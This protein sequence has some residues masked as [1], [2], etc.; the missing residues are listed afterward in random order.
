MTRVLPILFFL[1]GAT[2]LIGEVVWM[3]MLGLVLG[4]T[5]WAASAAVSVWMAGMAVGAAIGSRLA[6][7]VRRH[8]LWYGLAEGVIGVFF[9]LSPWLA[10]RLVMLGASL[11]EDLSGALLV[12]IGQRFALAVAALLLPTLLMGLTLPLLVERLRGSGLAQRTGLLYGVNT[13]G[14]ATGVLATAYFLLPNLGESGS[15]ALAGLMCLL[16]AVVAVFAESRVPAAAGGVGR[17]AVPGT[18]VSG[19]LLLAAAMGFASL[20]AEL[21][22]IRLLVLLLGSRVYAFAILL[23]VYLVGIAGGALLVRALG[24]RIDDPVRAL[25]VVQGL[26]SVMLGV[27]IVV[28]GWAT[29]VYA[30]LTTVV[31]LR[32]TFLNIQVLELVGTAVL[33][34]PVTLLFGASFPLAVAAD[35][36]RRSDGGHAG[37]VSAANTI[38]A[39]GGAVAAPFLLI[40]WLGSQITLLLLVG[41]HAAV[42]LRLRRDRLGV[43]LAVTGLVGAVICGAVLR[44]DWLVQRFAVKQGWEEEVLVV[45]EDLGATVMVRRIV[46]PA[47]EWTSLE[48]NGINVAGSSPALLAIQQLQGQLPMLQHPDPRRV[49]HIGFGS[50]GTCWAVSR[51]PVES[52]HVIEISPRV[53]S[54][55]HR[56]FEPINRHVLDD[57]RVRT[58]V[59][60]G[61]NY[62]LAT[63]NTYDVILS[64]SIHPVFSGNGALY[65]VDYFRLCR[66]RLGPDGVVSMWLPLY[67][68]DRESYLRILAAFHEVFPNTAVWYDR[69]TVNEFTV[70]TGT[71]SQGPVAIRWDQLDNPELAESLGIAGIA[72]PTDLAANLLLGP[73]EVA[74]LVRGFPAHEDDLP[75]VEYTAGRTVNRLVTWL[76][77]LSMVASVR[78]EQNPFA[79]DAPVNWSR[80]V[81]ERDA[82]LRHAHTVLEQEIAAGS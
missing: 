11:G 80:A 63:E 65:T 40:P 60:D 42:A 70:V 56:W 6:A 3:R 4:N 62:L 24:H 46:E 8:V 52:I 28:L 43:G 1:S 82:S 32:A 23:G 74:I 61:R 18:V 58:I 16:V 49:A 76:E 30:G 48:L 78:T 64:D 2:A 67:S 54:A 44:P 66:K 77:N 26:T 72:D 13:F 38:G 75:F 12:G 59:N 35:P 33:F 7:R 50:G 68:L 47:G 29:S 15:L 25:S 39:I 69:S 79:P 10:D 21:V 27:Q 31:Q 36:S 71:V 51:H 9:S 57:P 81:A 41:V 14:A 53:L 22:W 5:V 19:F 37:A 34:L 45:D 73:A 17:V 20:A 55:S